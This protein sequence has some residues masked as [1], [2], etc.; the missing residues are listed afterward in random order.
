MDA[1]SV[2]QGPANNPDA[3]DP[4]VAKK[5]KRRKYSAE[6]KR[7]ILKEAEACT[8]LG[9]MGQLLRR[10]GLYSSH[11]TNWRRE[12]DAGGNAGLAP[13]TRGRKPK[14]QTPERKRLAE[15][16][17]ENKRLQREKARLEAKL[18]R[19]DLMLDLQKKAHEILEIELPPAP[20]PIDE[21]DI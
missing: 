9:D 15:L 13:K 21:D 14:P 18:K 17:K 5:P 11:L 3:P 16:E 20:P 6:Y 19:A 1:M 2:N 7:R 12:R 4:E 8:K 10:E